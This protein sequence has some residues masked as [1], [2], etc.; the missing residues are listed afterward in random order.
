[1]AFARK[2]L[3][4][5]LS[6]GRLSKI[7]Q[8]PNHWNK[9]ILFSFG[10]CLRI[11]SRGVGEQYRELSSSYGGFQSSIAR[12]RYHILVHSKRHKLLDWSSTSSIGPN[13]FFSSL[14][15]T[16]CM[17]VPGKFPGALQYS[18]PHQAGS[19]K[20]RLAFDLPPVVTACLGCSKRASSIPLCVKHVACQGLGQSICP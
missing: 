18:T 6:G 12:S 11:V 5:V 20:S 13:L 16:T 9:D 4:Q 15:K 14:P 10:W 7:T 3:G 1:M 8:P 2:V 19:P 17:P